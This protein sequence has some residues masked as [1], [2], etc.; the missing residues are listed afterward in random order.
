MSGEISDQLNLVFRSFRT[1]EQLHK[2]AQWLSISHFH[3]SPP[4][5]N[6]FWL[7]T[8]TESLQMLVDLHVSSSEVHFWFCETLSGELAEKQH[9]VCWCSQLLFSFENNGLA[10]QHQTLYGSFG[11]SVWKSSASPHVICVEDGHD[12]HGIFGSLV[13]WWPTCTDEDLEV[14]MVNKNRVFI[15]MW[16]VL[17]IICLTLVFV[18]ITAWK[19][20]HL[21]WTLCQ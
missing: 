1:W 11:A 12:A 7:S 16:G 20:Q 5:Q 3:R 8:M 10:L 21:N 9:V 6:H 18:V 2:S 4:Q 14:K 13:L 17:R 19:V 15:W